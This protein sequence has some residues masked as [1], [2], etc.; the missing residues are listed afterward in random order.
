V[1]KFKFEPCSTTIEQ[2]TFDIYE[3]K[4]EY[5]KVY[6]DESVLLITNRMFLHE[7]QRYQLC[8]FLGIHQKI[9]LPADTSKHCVG[10]NFTHWLFY[11][12]PVNSIIFSEGFNDHTC[13]TPLSLPDTT[14]RE[15]G[16]K[17][18]SIIEFSFWK[19]VNRFSSLP[20]NASRITTRLSNVAHNRS[21]P[22]L[23]NLST[24]SYE[25]SFVQLL[26]AP[27]LTIAIPSHSRICHKGICGI[28]WCCSQPP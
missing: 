8:L 19:F 25:Y 1:R 15:S 27:F 10:E 5:S 9:F 13:T 12:W 23:L 7:L 6:F 16:V 28:L 11:I 24:F 21:L 14:Y 18:H 4:I 3:A 2:Y 17:E 26:N 22:Q 20:S